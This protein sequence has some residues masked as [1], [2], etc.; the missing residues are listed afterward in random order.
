MKPIE[1]IKCAIEKIQAAMAD[2]DMT[3]AWKRNQM[4]GAVDILNEAKKG[5]CEHKTIGLVAVN[6]HS[7]KQYICAD[8]GEAIDE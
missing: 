3:D 2:C 8:C 6:G 5:L 1:L 4:E 7:T